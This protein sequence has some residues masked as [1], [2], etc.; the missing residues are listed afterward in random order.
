MGIVSQEKWSLKKL[1]LRFDNLKKCAT[2]YLLFTLFG[3]LGILLLATVLKRGVVSNWWM[4]QHFQ[5]KFLI[6]S[7]VQELA[8]RG[9]L[10]PRLKSIFVSP[11]AVILINALLFAFIHIVFPQPLQLLPLG[12][13]GGIGFATIYYYYPN[14]LLITASHAVLNFFVVLFCFFSFQQSC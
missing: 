6:V 5:Y 10:I 14:L 7:F 13:I 3:T 9:F 8:F 11:K 2:P 1:G 4:L 12:M